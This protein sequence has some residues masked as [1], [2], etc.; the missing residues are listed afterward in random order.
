[1]P[2]PPHSYYFIAPQDAQQIHD[3]WKVLYN[4]VDLGGNDAREY[5][6]SR[7]W[8]KI[9]VNRLGQDYKMRYPGGAFGTAGKKDAV[10]TLLRGLPGAGYYGG[11]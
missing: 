7:D 10:N 5:M 9:D 3:L 6:K 8:K 1:M 11:C 4:T 2:N